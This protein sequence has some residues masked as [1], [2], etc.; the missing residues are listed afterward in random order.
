MLLVVSALL[1]GAPRATA[2]LD[3]P[4]RLWLV[5]QRAFEDRA[6]E[7]ALHEQYARFKTIAA[8][9]AFRAV[10]RKIGL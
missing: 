1:L 2:A 10:L 3:E 5:A 8:E 4:G 9:P 7:F 6:V